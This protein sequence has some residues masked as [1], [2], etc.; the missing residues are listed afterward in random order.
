MN[1]SFG[2]YCLRYFGF[3]LLITLV[4]A[5]LVYATYALAP[6][7]AATLF[8]GRMGLG[9]VS[10]IVP[11]MMV[12]QVFYRKEA[13]KMTSRESWLM[14]FAFAV[15]AFAVN[16]TL[17]WGSWQFVPLSVSETNDLSQLWAN[18]RD[19]LLIIAA[20]FA[21]V[22]VLLNKLMFWSAFRGEIKAAE[23]KAA[24]KG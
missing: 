18:G 4:I 17:V 3:S 14:A 20:I 22:L 16:L 8:E 12:A 1:R 21:V 2:Y 6:D 10:V 7:L 9:V 5:V 13:R 11:A 15:L 23:R 24:R 19:I